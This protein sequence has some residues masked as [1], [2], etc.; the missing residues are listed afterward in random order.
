MTIKCAWC[1]KPK[2]KIADEDWDD[3]EEGE[4]QDLVSHGICDECFARE[5][6]EVGRRADLTEGVQVPG[7]W[8]PRHGDAAGEV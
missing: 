5:M 2:I 4:L 6:A 7:L 1:G 8:R 3:A